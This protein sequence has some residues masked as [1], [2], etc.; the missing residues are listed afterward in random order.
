MTS[1]LPGEVRRYVDMWALPGV[2]PTNIEILQQLKTAD[3]HHFTKNMDVVGTVS[4]QD[5]ESQRWKKTHLL[6]VRTDIW[7]PDKKEMTDS[8]NSLKEK[9]RLELK[10]QIKR[11]G[12]LDSKQAAQLDE[13]LEQDL[14][15]QTETGEIE[16][17][18]LV[19][20]LFKTTGT[21]VR[22]CGTIEEVTTSEV[23]NSIGSNRTLLTTAVM[24]PRSEFVTSIQENH[25]TFRFPSIFTFCFYDDHRMW[26]LSLKQRWFSLGVD[27]EVEVEKN[28]SENWMANSSRLGRIV[29]C[30]S[31]STH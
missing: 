21:R 26:H 16:K 15:M 12:R 17:R 2:H 29:S 18:R 8:L 14:L 1:Q 13:Q 3:T 9:R 24:L 19:L 30:D 10:K 5:R 7:R 11:G 4:E 23:H 28:R 25:R 31:T 20:K 22:W 27:F 6:G